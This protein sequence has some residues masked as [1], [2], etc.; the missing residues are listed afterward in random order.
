MHRPGGRARTPSCNSGSIWT[1]FYSTWNSGVNTIANICIYDATTSAGGNDFVIDDISFR[2]F[3]TTTDSVYI[4]VVPPDT[5]YSVHDTTLCALA[6]S[7]TLNATAG[8]VSY[9]W[10]T[11]STAA[12]I[13]VSSSGTYWVYNHGA[14]SRTL[15]DTFH[16]TFIPSPI[17]NIGNDTAFCVGDTLTLTSS[18]PA[19]YTHLWNTGATDTSIIATI[20]G[21]YWLAVN[22][23]GCVVTDTIHITV[24]PIPV[25]DLGPD[26]INCQGVPDTLTS[27]TG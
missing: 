24:S 15:I 27:A 5:T 12:T 20:S 14:C 22:N 19:G 3:C 13:S 7:L 8:Y 10:N 26:Y 1:G 16:V 25:V 4:A 6:G 23:A 21:T 18:Q 2:Q 9:D 11:G 17:V